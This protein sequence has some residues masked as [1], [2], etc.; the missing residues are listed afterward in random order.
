MPTR[1]GYLTVDVFTERAFSGNPVAVMLDAKGLSTD[2]MHRVA[3][4]FNYSESTFV[5]PPDDPSHTARVRIFTPKDEIPFA[6]HPNVGTA[7]AIAHLAERDGKTI[8]PIL[9]FEEGAGLVPVEL[10]RD[11]SGRVAGAMLTAPRPLALGQRVPPASVAEC[12]GLEPDAIATSRHEPVI[13]SVG[14]SFAIA[15]VAVEALGRAKPNPAAFACL[16]ANA[17][18]WGATVTCLPVG[19][20]N[21]DKTAELTFFEGMSLLSGFHADAATEHDVVKQYVLNQQGGEEESALPPDL[22][23]VIDDRLRASAVTA[24]LRTLSSVI[25]EHRLERIDLLK[26]NVEKSELEVLQGLAPTDW[27]KIRQMVIEVDLRESVDPIVALLEGHGFEVL[28]E[29]DPLLRDTAL[30]Y[31]YAI[32]P[33][34]LP[35]DTRLIREQAQTAGPIS[36]P[37]DGEV[38]TPAA[39]RRF[40]R[41]RL[42]RYMVPTAFV[43]LDKLPLTPNGKVDRQALPAPSSEGTSSGGAPVAPVTRPL[44]ETETAVAAI[45]KELLQVQ[46]VGVDDDFFELG[47]HS[48][49]AI[50]AVSRIRDVFGAE[51]QTRTLFE[52]STLGA[53]SKVLADVKDSSEGARRIAPRPGTG[54][55]PLSFAQEQLWFLHQLA[56][57][58]PAYNM[59]DV[60][61]LKG[62]YQAGALRRAVEELARRHEILRTQFVERDGQPV[63]VVQPTVALDLVDVDLSVFAQAQREAEWHRV[64]RDSGR[65]PFDLSRA[66]LFRATVVHVGGQDV[67]LLLVIHHIVADEWSMEL[68]HH[69]LAAL[70]D[71]FARGKASP[72]TELPIQYADYTGWQ[73][74][75]LHGDALRQE[76]G[77]WNAELKGAPTVLDLVT[78]KP[79]PVVQTFRGATELFEL[80]RGTLEGLEQ[81]GHAEHA[82]LFMVLEAAF[83]TLLH[84]YT[85]QDDLL[86]GTPISGRTQTETE[87]LIGCF[88]NTV[89]LRSQLARDMSFRG[90]L[91]QARERALSAYAHPEL[92]LE[93]LVAALAPQRDASRTPL[94]QVLFVLH[95][96]DGVSQVSKVSGN[97]ELETGTSKFDVTLMFSQTKRGLEG[98]IEYSTDLFEADSIRRMCGHLQTLLQAIVRDPDQRVSSLPLLTDVERRRLQIEWNDTAVMFPAR[99]RRVHDLIDEQ[100][101]RAPNRTAVVFEDEAL[102]YGDLERRAN[103]VAH[104]LR[105]LGVGPD[106]LVG[107]LVERSIDM[108]VGLLGILKAGGAYVP[109]D[110]S[111]PAARLAHMVEDSGMRVLVTH[112]DLEGVLPVQP[113][114]V[115]RLDSDREAIARRPGTRP[116]GTG[117]GP[118]DLAYVLYT[119]GST[120]KPKGVAVPHSAL[121]NFLLSMQRAPGFTAADTLLA[122]TTLSFDIAGLELYLPLVCGGRVA[123]A[124]REDALD[125]KQLMERMRRADCTVMQATPITWRALVDAGW[126]GAERLKALCG[127]EALPPGLAEELLPRCAQLW[128]LYGPTETTI[129]STAERVT[130]VARRPVSIGRPIANTQVFVLDAHGNMIPAGLAGELYIGGAGVARGYLRRDE[131]TRERFVPSPVSSGERLYRTGDLARWLPDGRLEWLGRTDQQVKVRGFRI[132]P[133]EIE[134]VIARHPAVREVVVVA[135][136]DVPGES[137][138]VAYLVAVNPPV[139]LADQLRASVRSGAPEYMMPSEFVLLAALP[140]T[141]NGKVDR[142]ALPVPDTGAG[143]TRGAGRNGGPAAA[144]P[145]ATEEIVMHAFRGVLGNKDFGVSDSFFDLGGHS[146]M[147]ARLMTQLRAVS[148]VDLPL[149][150][151]FERPTVAGLAQAIDAV[152]WSRRAA[153][154]E[155]APDREEI[156]L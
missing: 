81:L 141:P 97:R 35:R 82:T 114:A 33:P 145:T 85:G 140:R 4:E 95:N 76:I 83:A 156:E 98:L 134:A 60:I 13:A 9:L 69:E 111:F 65:R 30:C 68:V 102:T 131:L 124:S 25:A 108:M 101:E 10:L 118:S 41:S 151:L 128:N 121:T 11:G 150:S 27:P 26:I 29:Q 16:Q 5:L 104:Y 24:Q 43:L 7:F 133:G 47:G 94:F 138:L 62:T 106:V 17:S 21:E 49:L 74:D 66:P 51:L 40:L 63:Q 50:K 19:V 64:V 113:P 79:R 8:G 22:D 38:L 132:E 149:R 126:G 130:S 52:H 45:W 55:W 84:R 129:W 117:A 105:E 112:R 31:V 123:I 91:R 12:V 93:H 61:P 103:Q 1:Y 154:Q 96:A 53:L 148:G 20:S 58:S 88:L 67:R 6:G 37:P 142:K 120:G 92:P 115:V 78:D 125:P 73:R 153:A 80:S 2:E 46:S 32:R 127:G 110:P 72:L 136:Q 109:L 39:L 89:V 18:A 86:V 28:V 56:P 71:A 42:P 36:L 44:T 3:A 77:F 15:E 122:V 144:P 146:L 14:L 107:L 152:Q 143:G 57:A 147:A 99:D 75:W 155:T 90:L 100:V 59:A 139:D 116:S 70:Y 23:E 54:P 48:L 137:R 135:R 87:G 119:S 34:A